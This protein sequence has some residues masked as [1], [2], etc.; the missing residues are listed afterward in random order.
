MPALKQ[1]LSVRALK[2]P[3]RKRLSLAALLLESVEN[4]P[5][6]DHALLGEL[7]KRSA[8]LRSGRVKGLTTEEAYG[9]SL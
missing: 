8:E 7:R 2:L 1:P 9:F 4:S 3:A 6:V 5:Q